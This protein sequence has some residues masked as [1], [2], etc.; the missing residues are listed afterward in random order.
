[1]R[2]TPYESAAAPASHSAVDPA[3]FNVLCRFKSN[4]PNRTKSNA[5]LLIRVFTPVVC[6]LRSQALLCREVSH[7]LKH[8][9][10]FQVPNGAVYT[11]LISRGA[12]L[13]I[14]F[15]TSFADLG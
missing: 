11:L 14:K 12:I 2:R 7:S 6:R 13:N 1:M 10:V 9:R 3:E 5:A 8:V 15:M 4:L